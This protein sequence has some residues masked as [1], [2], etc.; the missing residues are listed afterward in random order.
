AGPNGEPFVARL[1][2]TREIRDANGRLVEQTSPDDRRLTVPIARFERTDFSRTPPRDY[3]LK[4]R[5][6]VPSAPGVYTAVVEVK[7]AAGNRTV[8]SK[9]ARF[10]VAGP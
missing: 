10:D 3:F 1:V 4:Y 2:S 8:R 9:P 6:P 7:D 5:F